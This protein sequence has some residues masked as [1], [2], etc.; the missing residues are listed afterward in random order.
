MRITAEKLERLQALTGLPQEQARKALEAADGDLLESLLLLERAGLIADAEVGRWSTG[1]AET[2][3]APRPARNADPQ[4][5][6][7]EKPEDLLRR[8]WHWLVYNR[9]EIYKKYD[10]SR[11]IRCPIGVL[12]GL[13]AVAWYVA[14]AALL[15]ALCTGWRFRLAGPQLGKH[16]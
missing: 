13:L 1:G 16:G 7:Q 15:I 8:C 14:A 3:L 4:P 11:Q 9:L 6:P 5:G 10:P 2:R 12:L